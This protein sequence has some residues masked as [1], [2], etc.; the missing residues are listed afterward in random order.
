MVVLRGAGLTPTPLP[1]G[2]GQ[3][4]SAKYSVNEMLR[5]LRSGFSCGQLQE[6]VQ[7]YFKIRVLFV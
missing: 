5:V 7:I 1:G 3:E 4:P 6:T 2:E